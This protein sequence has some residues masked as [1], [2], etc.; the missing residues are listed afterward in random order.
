MARIY[1][2]ASRFCAFLNLSRECAIGL[3]YTFDDAVDVSSFTSSAKTL[4]INTCR[5][6]VF[7]IVSKVW[8]NL[9]YVAIAGESL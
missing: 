3:T 7:L 9:M 8:T 5:C 2:V 6:N 4:L 1:G